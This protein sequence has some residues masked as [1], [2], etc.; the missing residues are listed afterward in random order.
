MKAK[1]GLTRRQYLAGAGATLATGALPWGTLAHAAPTPFGDV[2]LAVFNPFGPQKHYHEFL[3]SIFFDPAK[4]KQ[5]AEFL[6]RSFQAQ[7]RFELGEWAM[8]AV[9]IWWRTL[10]SRRERVKVSAAGRK[11]A[12]QIQKLDP[13]HPAG[14]LWMAI[15]AGTEALSRGVLESLHLVPELTKNLERATSNAIDYFHGL[16]IL[17]N[18]KLYAKVPGFPM[19]V[20]DIDK[21]MALFEQGKSFQQGVFALWYLFRAEAELQHSGK[22]AAFAWLDRMQQEVEPVDVTTA[23]LYETSLYD[24]KI[25]RQKVES[26]N[27]DRYRW[28]PLLTVPQPSRS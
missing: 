24:A 25:F 20:G 19:S 28:D 7:Q 6:W 21:A 22:E 17:V 8:P 14:P 9:F 16:G 5:L 4:S 1:A 12:S 27:Y 13:S 10:E 3:R 18:A 2:D 15:F 23:Y 26:D 11:M